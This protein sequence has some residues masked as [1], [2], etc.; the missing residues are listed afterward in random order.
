MRTSKSKGVRRLATALAAAFVL[1]AAAPAGAESEP[2]YKFEF[3]YGQSP[4][5]QVKVRCGS[6]GGW[7]AVSGTVE[8]DCAESSAEL[9]L[10]I[11]DYAPDVET[12]DHNCGER[13]RQVSISHSSATGLGALLV[14]VQGN[15]V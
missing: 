14:N 5:G 2:V 8:L 6:S 15:C 9:D 4:E 7:T 3:I 1:G 10:E 13:T 12:R 11:G